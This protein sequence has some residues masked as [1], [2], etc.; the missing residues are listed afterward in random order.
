MALTHRPTAEVPE[1]TLLTIAEAA[2]RLEFSRPYVFKLCDAG[3]LG[4]IVVIEYGHRRIHASALDAYAAART[5][6]KEGA[7]SPRD[8][9]VDAGLYDYP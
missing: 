4:E 9:G 7:P 6:Q 1:D 3:K 5:K 2:A 8:A